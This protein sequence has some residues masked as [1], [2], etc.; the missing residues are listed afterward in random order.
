[1][2]ILAS[3]SKA[4]QLLLAN[5]GLR[6]VAQPAEIDERAVEAAASREG[7]DGAEIAIRLAEAKAV[8]VARLHPSAEVIGADQTLVIDGRLLHKPTSLVEARDQLDR[9]CGRTHYLHAAIALVT[10]GQPVWSTVETAEMRVR[11]F[12]AAERDA[13]L[14]EEGEAVLGSVG[15]YRLEGPS[16]RLFDSIRGDYFAILG[17]PLL[18]LLAA[19]RQHA[20][21]TLPTGEVH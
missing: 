15:A 19:L 7:L 2:L 12:T 5:A 17:L 9:L 21:H 14:S 6:F 11:P 13:V 3:Q 1:M 10:A 18:P 8:A 16:V 20:P 4:R